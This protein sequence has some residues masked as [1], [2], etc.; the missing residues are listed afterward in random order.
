MSYVIAAVILLL[1]VV[2]LAGVIPP[3]TRRKGSDGQHDHGDHD[4]GVD[5]DSVADDF[6]PS[7]VPRPPRSRRFH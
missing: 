1:A 6:D 7:P 4:H 3:R 5:W 2:F